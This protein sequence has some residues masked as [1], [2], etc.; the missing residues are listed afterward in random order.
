MTEHDLLPY[1]RDR[2]MRHVLSRNGL[3]REP[4]YIDSRFLFSCFIQFEL[5]E[6]LKWAVTHLNSIRAWMAVSLWLLLLAQLLHMAVDFGR[7][8]PWRAFLFELLLPITAIASIQFVD[9]SLTANVVRTALED[10]CAALST[11]PGRVSLN[12]L[13]L[14]FCLGSL[15]AADAFLLFA[16]AVCAVSCAAMWAAFVRMRHCADYVRTATE[17]VARLSERF[18]MA[19]VDC[20]GVLDEEELGRFFKSYNQ[21]VP[22][23]QREAMIAHWDVHRDGGL[24]LDALRMWF[25]R[26]PINHVTRANLLR[27]APTDL[28]GEHRVG[29]PMQQ[30]VQQWTEQEV[31]HKVEQEDDVDEDED[32]FEELDDGPRADYNPFD[33]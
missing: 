14:F 15:E 26:V 8:D 17:S 13:I 31:E 25:E 2:L 4:S 20:D 7:G 9:T 30:H 18:A 21:S 33:D 6:M 5:F 1:R 27:A 29:G 32:E 16:V 3:L 10:R 23:W 12:L 19:D 22:R 28:Y 11:V 24:R